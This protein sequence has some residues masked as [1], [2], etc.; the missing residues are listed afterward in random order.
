M[1][2]FS[3]QTYDRFFRER[4]PF[5]VRKIAL[6][7]ILLCGAFCN[8]Q[9][10]VPIL[11]KEG[12][13]DMFLKAPKETDMTMRLLSMNGKDAVFYLKSGSVYAPA[14]FSGKRDLRTKYSVPK[15]DKVDFYK[16]EIIDD[17]TYFIKVFSLDAKGSSDIIG[18]LYISKSGEY[19]TFS[20]DISL[21]AI[22]LGDFCVINVSPLVM[23]FSVDKKTNKKLGVFESIIYSGASKDGLT[24]VPLDIYDLA[25]SK[26][27]Q[28]LTSRRYAFRSDRR[29]IVLLFEK[30][31]PPKRIQVD[32]MES[33]SSPTDTVTINDKGPR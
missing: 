30:P 6:C 21:D 5:G 4:L 22:S 8:A 2:M 25:A 3:M 27:P 17:K 9:D 24:S 28:H 7:L 29:Y 31:L 18:G 23:G 13:P 10:A 32:L 15:S 12:A 20:V 14:L 26:N 11:G 19:K 1:P 16:R 33:L